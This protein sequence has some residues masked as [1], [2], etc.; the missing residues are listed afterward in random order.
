MNINNVGYNHCP[1]F[2]RQFKSRMD[3]TP[4]QYRESAKK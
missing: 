2:M 4:T 3:M 1:H